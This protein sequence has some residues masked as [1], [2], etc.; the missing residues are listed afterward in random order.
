MVLYGGMRLMKTDK[1]KSQTDAIIQY[2]RRNKSITSLQAFKLFNATRLSSIIY[3]LKERG[4][5][6]ET[7][8][9]QGKNRYGH[10][11]S[12]AIYHLVKDL[13]EEVE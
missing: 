4:F 12:Y 3:V 6:I 2:L 9:T 13:E 10:V 11:T 5:G 7:E 8:M 1:P